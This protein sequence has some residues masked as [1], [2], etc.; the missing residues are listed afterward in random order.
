MY[1]CS[2]SDSNETTY[3]PTNEDC[4]MRQVT[5]PNFCKVCIE[6]LWLSLLRR[7]NLI[8][9]IQESCRGTVQIL[10]LALVP[11]AQFRE[12]LIEVQE[13][14]TITWFKDGT[15]FP[16]FTNK[17]RLEVDADDGPGLYTINVKYTTDEVKVDRE[18]L[19]TDRL[20]YRVRQKCESPKV[21]CTYILWLGWR[22]S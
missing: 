3:R 6:G 21:T 10:D 15:A 5:T 18:S 17:T 20:K 8:D 22:C 19:L 9:D 4:L 16:E 12:S 1:I 14:F 11:L 13:S 2:F 7:V